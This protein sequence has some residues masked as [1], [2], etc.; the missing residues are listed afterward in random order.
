MYIKA[1]MLKQ[2]T[3]SAKSKVPL[4]VDNVIGITCLTVFLKVLNTGRKQKWQ[5]N[6][7]Q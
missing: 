6:I 7:H 4:T 3:F 5:M 1:F 2:T